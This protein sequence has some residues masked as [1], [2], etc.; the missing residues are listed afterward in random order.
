MLTHLRVS[1]GKTKGLTKLIQQ[2]IGSILSLTSNVTKVM[3]TSY[4]NKIQGSSKLNTVT[5]W[6]YLVCLMYKSCMRSVC[7]SYCVLVM[8]QFFILYH[9]SMSNVWGL[10]CFWMNSVCK[11]TFVWV[12][13]LLIIPTPY[14]TTEVC[15]G[16]LFIFVFTSQPGRGLISE[17]H[18]AELRRPGTHVPEVGGK[19]CL[20]VKQNHLQGHPC[21]CKPFL[22]T[23]GWPMSPVKTSSW[24]IF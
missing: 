24:L 18:N 4:K 1:W 14:P 22:F 16:E 13:D 17:V 20:E 6:M 11:M 9:L 21:R 2:F 12:L 5:H 23:T 10:Y 7:I 8:Y 19:S 3:Q 15:S